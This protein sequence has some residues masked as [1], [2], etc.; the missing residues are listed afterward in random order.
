MKITHSKEIMGLISVIYQKS[1]ALVW[2]VDLMA[3]SVLHKN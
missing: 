3:K 2:I 1:A